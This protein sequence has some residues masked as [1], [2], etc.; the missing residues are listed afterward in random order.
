[1]LFFFFQAEDGIRDFHV[2]GVQTCALPISF[3]DGLR[4]LFTHTSRAGGRNQADSLVGGDRLA[5]AGIA[6]DVAEYAFRQMIVS[7]YGS[8][9]MLTG[10][11]G[12]GC[13]FRGLPYGYVA[14]DGGDHR[15]PGP[16]GHRK[17]KG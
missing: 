14:A 1:V 3:G 4:Y 15:V 9:D 8:D 6:K 10:Y 17:V 16:Y 11:S 13:F 5:Y 2:T 12:Q 7:E